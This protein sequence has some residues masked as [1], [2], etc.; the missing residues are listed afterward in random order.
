MLRSTCS[1]LPDKTV[2]RM[3][4]YRNPPRARLPFLSFL[5][6]AFEAPLDTGSSILIIRSSRH[7]TGNSIVKV[8]LF[9]IF[10]PCNRGEGEGGIVNYERRVRNRGALRPVREIVSNDAGIGLNR[11]R[12]FS[13][14]GKF[15]SPIRIFRVFFHFKNSAM[16]LINTVHQLT[17]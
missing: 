13:G 8:K 2:D 17:A 1:P 7:Y 10:S 11:V 16:Q 4:A 6:S 3:I 15:L 14:Y 5:F 9:E 12:Y